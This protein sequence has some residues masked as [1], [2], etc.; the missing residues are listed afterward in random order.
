MDVRLDVTGAAP[1]GARCL[2]RRTHQAEGWAVVEMAAAGADGRSWRT[3][4]PAEL[5][6]SAYPVQYYFELGATNGAVALHPG[7]N[8]TLSNQ[9]YF[10]VRPG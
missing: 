1:A 10:V 7:F 6:S 8:E 9:P 2:Y 4:L 3:T 5:T